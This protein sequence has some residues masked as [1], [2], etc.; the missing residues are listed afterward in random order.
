MNYVTMAAN[1]YF[2]TYKGEYILCHFLNVAYWPLDGS[3]AL[4]DY[5]VVLYC[6][7]CPCHRDEV[8]V[9]RNIEKNV[10]NFNSTARESIQVF[11]RFFL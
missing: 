11:F 6:N 4:D 8:H 7:S 5:V 3:V 2:L 9:W 1:K 10:D